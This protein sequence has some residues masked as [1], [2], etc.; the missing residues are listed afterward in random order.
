MLALSSAEVETLP[1]P[2]DGRLAT[3]PPADTRSVSFG[4]TELATGY[5]QSLRFVALGKL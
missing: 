1:P 3:L 2:D 5:H 4:L